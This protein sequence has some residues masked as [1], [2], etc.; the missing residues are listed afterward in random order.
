MFIQ[1]HLQASRWALWFSFARHYASP[2]LT[3]R[4]ASPSSP[5]LHDGGQGRREGADEGG[6]TRGLANTV[7]LKYFRKVMGHTAQPV[8]RTC[9]SSCLRFYNMAPTA[10]GSLGNWCLHHLIGPLGTLNEETT[11][12]LNELFQSHRELWDPRR[13][14]YRNRRLKTSRWLS[15]QIAF[16][17]T[18]GIECTGITV[19]SNFNFKWWSL[20]H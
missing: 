1:F 18:T 12:Y 13:A 19:Y 2:A 14:Q 6:A 17:S 20:H 7:F 4:L 3:S 11:C 10:T 15:M 9:L 5:E 16:L 8:W